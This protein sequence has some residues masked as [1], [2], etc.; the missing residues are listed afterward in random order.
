M[1]NY[2]LGLALFDFLPVVAGGLGIYL[3]CRYCAGRAC[4]RGPWIWLIPSTALAGG[5]FKAIWKL[6]LALHG[7]DI[8]WM[9]ELLF[10]CLAGAYVPMTALVLGSLHAAR[11]GRTLAPGWWRLPALIVAAATAGAYFLGTAGNA[12]A[13]SGLL[14]ALVA[15]ASLLTLLSLIGHAIARRDRIA[16]A[17]FA[18]SLALSYVLV[19]LSRMEQTV[20]L[21]WVEQCIN[22]AGN[23][24]LIAAAWRLSR[25][26]KSHA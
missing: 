24:A 13:G 25:G 4:Y 9:S 10:Y 11:H 3:V 18:L 23:G 5:A 7:P 20:T 22:L 16:A 12:R 2:T 15:L 8:Q 17:A 21:Q 6:I 19:G 1:Q 14:V 26:S